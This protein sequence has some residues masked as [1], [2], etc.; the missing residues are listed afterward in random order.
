MAAFKLVECT[1]IYTYTH[2]ENNNEY[3]KVARNKLWHTYR[4]I[5]TN[6]CE[7]NIVFFSMSIYKTE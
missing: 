3:I 6:M 4:N 1:N 2:V 7:T 5:N